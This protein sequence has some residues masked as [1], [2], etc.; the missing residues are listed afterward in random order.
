MQFREKG[1][2]NMDMLQRLEDSTAIEEYS[3]RQGG[4][5]PKH[6]SR[7]G[8][9]T[10]VF[11]VPLSNIMFI[12]SGTCHSRFHGAMGLPMLPSLRRLFMLL[13]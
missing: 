3:K 1:V 5:N 8:G 10:T 11:L 13:F 2:H 6:P 4:S 12:F 7:G 9:L